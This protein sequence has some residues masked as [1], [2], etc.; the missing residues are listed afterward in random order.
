MSRILRAVMVLTM[1]GAVLASA[2]CGGPAPAPTAAPVAPTQAAAPTKAP[3]SNYP[4]KD[5]TLIVPF[6]PGGGFDLQSRIFAPLWQQN[7]P[8]KVN[9]IVDNQKGAGGNLGSMKLMKSPADGLTIA[10]LS[11]ATL[12]QAQVTGQ[13]ENMDIRNLSY[14]GQL[15]YEEGVVVVSAASNLKT[16]ADL[17]TKEL[18]WGVTTDSIFSAAVF[19]SKLGL[20]CRNVMFDG[21]AEQGLAA[22]RG[23]IDMM[24]DS[25][26]AM[27]RGVD[28]G[29][30]K[31]IGM[32]VIGDARTTAWSALP[33]SK[34]LGLDLGDLKYVAGSARVLAGPAGVP[35]DVLKIMRD[36]SAKAFASPDF[37]AA[38]EKASF[39]SA[40]GTGEDALTTV[41]KIVGI[42]EANKTILMSLVQ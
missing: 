9:V 7:L 40:P 28:N 13:L 18:R 30:G 31:L 21:G 41:Q 29:E 10:V 32:M 27:K 11:P 2:A 33:T 39:I 25:V 19:C 5:I 6:S 38:M 16:V 8:Q 37:K 34:E 26:S 15:S 4:T 36:A 17:K 24:V 35:A 22:M 14:I 42:Y 3:V 23:D 1:V 12:A 20:K